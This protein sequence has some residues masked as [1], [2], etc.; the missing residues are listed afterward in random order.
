MLV[1]IRLYVCRYIWLT[2]VF[3][4]TNKNRIQLT[5][6]KINNMFELKIKTN[7]HTHKYAEDKL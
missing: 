3:R 2:D 4:E 1:D 5:D 6:L 7:T